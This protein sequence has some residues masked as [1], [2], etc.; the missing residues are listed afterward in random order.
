MRQIA[1]AIRLSGL[2]AFISILV[3]GTA[4]ISGAAADPVDPP[5]AQR[6]A[7]PAEARLPGANGFSVAPAADSAET[8]TNAAASKPAEELTLEQAIE[9]ALQ[10]HPK[11]REAA[12][13]TS[14]AGAR[15]GEARS[16]LGPQLFGMTEYLRST[17]NGIGNTSYYDPYGALPRM[18]GINHDLAANDFEQ[19]WDTSNNY[20]GGLALSQFLFD[21]GRRRGLVAQRQ[22]EAAA[23]ASDQQ[24]TQLDIIFEVSRRYFGV[25]AAKQLI[26]VYEKGVEQRK[27]HLHE[28]EVKASAGLRPQLDIYVTRAEVERTQLNLV[29]ARNNYADARVGLDNAM[30]LTDSAPAYHL[31]DV[32]TYTQVKDDLDSLIKAALQARPDLKAMQDQLAAMGARVTQFKSDYYPTV[33]AVAGYAG[34]GTGL[35]AANNFNAGIVVT[36]PIFN[37]FL[38]TDQTAE[39]KAR[40]HAIAGAMDDLRQQVILQ[41]QTAFLDWQASLQRIEFAQ[42]ALSASSVE[43]ELAE[44]RYQAGLA[45][46]VELEDAQRHYTDD[47]AAFA[48]ALYGFALSKAA[49]DQ[50][51]A[52]S[53][54]KL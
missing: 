33:N 34:M 36:W 11:I 41:V 38:T 18:T 31:A 22:F 24:L 19:S 46:I 29:N 20:A 12:A 45:D 44:K 9:V 32:L 6:T 43:L 3:C 53:L 40:Q 47:D 7:A 15:I 27:Y 37:S 35:P 5:R 21:F 25:L 54:D 42:Q 51:T 28:A 48:N 2:A 8:R 10:N 16:Y 4:G 52:R 1:Q 39:T 13:D 30:G 17:D 14:A 23:A 50:A 49:V 26:R